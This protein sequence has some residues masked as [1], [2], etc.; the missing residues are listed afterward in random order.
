MTVVLAGTASGDFLPPQLISSGHT[1]KSL[2]K[3]VNFPSDW[4]LATTPKH[5]SNEET[6]VDY[7]EKINVPYGEK[8]RKDMQLPSDFQ[9][10]VLFDDF[11]GQSYV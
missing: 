11:S 3:N 7:V 8:K 6:M 4:H 2:P 9:A 10:L 1:L 5:W